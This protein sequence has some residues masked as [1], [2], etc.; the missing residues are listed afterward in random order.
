[1]AT[2]QK[3][4]R[5]PAP[6]TAAR[7]WSLLWLVA[8]GLSVAV[9]AAIATTKSGFLPALPAKIALSLTVT[10]LFATSLAAVA[11]DGRP[12]RSYPRAPADNPPTDDDVRVSPEADRVYSRRHSRL[13]A[14]GV[15][16]DA[17]MLL[18]ADTRF[19]IHELERLLAAGCPLATAL[20]ILEPA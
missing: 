11:R 7:A 13:A 14:L 4:P 10:L 17:A 3:E 20:R 8:I 18:A 2:R 5:R 19:S 1:M 9:V 16:G 6:D 12:D 15:A